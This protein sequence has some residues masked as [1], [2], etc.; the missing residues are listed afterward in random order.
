MQHEHH[1]PVSLLPSGFYGVPGALRCV[2]MLPKSDLVF[3]LS[4][5]NVTTHTFL[6]VAHP[7]IRTIIQDI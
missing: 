4:I 7:E 1:S 6:L 3:K 5:Q 2:C